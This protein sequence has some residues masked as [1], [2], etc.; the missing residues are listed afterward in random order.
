[1]IVSAAIAEFAN[2]N[3]VAPASQNFTFMFIPLLVIVLGML[4]P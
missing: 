2:I 4:P 1:L 3:A